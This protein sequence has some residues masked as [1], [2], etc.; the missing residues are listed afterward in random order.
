MSHNDLICVELGVSKNLEN[1]FDFKFAIVI[2]S[3][4]L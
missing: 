4:V 1:G 2:W 3:L